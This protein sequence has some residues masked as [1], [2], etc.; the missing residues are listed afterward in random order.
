VSGDRWSPAVRERWAGPGAGSR[1]ASSRF[2][3]ERAAQRDPRMVAALLEEHGVRGPILDAPCGTGRL[4]AALRRF[5]Q[6]LVGLDVSAAML[7]HASGAPA[8]LVRGSLD[9]LPFEDASF[10]AVVACRYL[11]HLREPGEIEAVLRELLRVSRRLL[12]ASFWDAASLPALRVR[13]GLRAAQPRTPLRRAELER[14]VEAAGGHVE[15][16]RASFRF[17]SQQ[18][19]FAA[20]RRAP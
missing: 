9:A 15:G 5:G 18:T 12:V 13:L 20:V 6:P 17:L 1:Y 10:D 3:G 14:L 11:H 7:A 2:A 8:T 16:Y 19:F 4:H